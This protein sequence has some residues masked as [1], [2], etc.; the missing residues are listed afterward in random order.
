MIKLII[1]GFILF[2]FVEAANA[3]VLPDA[4]R[5]NVWA[6]YMR[7]TSNRRDPMPL[8][9]TDLRAAVNAVDQWVNDNA[10]SYNSAIP[11]PARTSLTTKQKV[12]LLLFIAKRRWEVE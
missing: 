7:L 10:G 9:K 11:L 12:E 3:A 4:D 6:E 2:L 8:S 1:I 5:K